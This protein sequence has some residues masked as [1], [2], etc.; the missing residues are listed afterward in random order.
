M[1]PIY[2]LVKEGEEIVDVKIEYPG[3]YTAQMLRYS[4]EYPFLPDYN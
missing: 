1:N 3:N 4:M 2:Q